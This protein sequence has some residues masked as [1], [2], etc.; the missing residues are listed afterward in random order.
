MF[1]RVTGA[2]A[3]LA[4]L[5]AAGAESVSNAT[6]AAAADGVAAT[7]VFYLS[8]SGYEGAPVVTPA[9]RLTV[10]ET[11]AVDGVPYTWWECAVA[12]EGGG[13]F[14]VRLLSERVPLTSPDGIG[15][16]HR[17]LYFDGE[18]TFDYRDGVT[19]A[20]L[21]PEIRFRED[22][23]PVPSRWAVYAD[24]FASVG[25]F[26]GHTIVRVE[27][28]PV[29]ARLDFA[30]P[31]IL[32]LRSDL[33]MAAQ[34]F[35][36]NDYV[37]LKPGDSAPQWR[38]Y[39][40][41]EVEAL[42]DAG[43]NLFAPSSEHRFWLREQ[44]VFFMGTPSY[45]DSLYRSNY[46]AGR[47]YIDEP[48]V[49]FG[50]DAA[51]PGQDLAGPEQFTEALATRVRSE[52]R[53]SRQLLDT[54]GFAGAVEYYRAPPN[55]WDTYYYSA[56]TQLAAGA[57][58]LIHEGRYKDRGYGW[59]PE[60]FFG[61]AGFEHLTF[62]DQIR[63]LNSFLRG[64]ARGWNA[65]F[66]VSVYPE[67]DPDLFADAFR[68]SYDM[69]ARY[70]WF[71][72]HPPVV[73]HQTM[74]DLGKVMQAHVRDQPRGERSQALRGAT[75]A[76]VL[77]PGY[78][79]DSGGSIW[80]MHK[81]QVS[82]GGVTYGEIAAA[83][84]GEAL[85]CSRHGIAYDIIQDETFVP[86][87][88]YER[89]VYVGKDAGLQ[90]VPPWPSPRA[91]R[92]LSV[93]ASPSVAV[94]IAAPATGPVRYT[95]A[96]AGSMVMDGSLDDWDVD[97]IPLGREEAGSDLIELT[98]AV[99]AIGDATLWA[100]HRET[101]L[102]LQFA[103]MDY[104]LRRQL[105]MEDYHIIGSDVVD[106][107]RPGISLE[108]PAVIITEIRPGS[109]AAEAGLR[110]GDVIR[111]INGRRIRWHFEV[112]GIMEAVGRGVHKALRFEITRNDRSRVGY[113]GD[114]SA[115]LGLAVDDAFLYVAADVQD[116]THSQ[117][118]S[119]WYLWQG[120]CLQIGLSPTLSGTVG[121]YSEQD[122]ELAFA[123]RDNGEAVVYRYQGRLGLPREA[124]EKATVRIRRD[125]ARTL[126]EAA[127]P[128]EDWM[129]LAPDL[130]RHCGINVV[131]NDHDGGDES[132]R[133][134]RLELVEGAMTRNKSTRDFA[135]VAFE[136]SVN[137]EKVSAALVWTRRA[138]A[139]SENHFG[140]RVAASSPES[141]R[142]VV[143]AALASLDSPETAPVLARTDLAINGDAREWDLRIET[144]SPPGRYAL[145]IRVEDEN[146]NI[147]ASDRLPVLIY[148]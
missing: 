103:Q 94:P 14:G 145:E 23:L 104:E 78:T 119:G 58:A 34:A 3:S 77:P 81:N 92:G 13:I 76:I 79:V 39:S 70:L 73:G 148:R 132:Q 53:T 57:R 33:L 27:P 31:R 146:G 46:Y 7:E 93:S 115:R 21:L 125:G 62:D 50:W 44:A 8:Q 96:R 9:L 120:D 35:G 19:G 131:I 112:W 99:P 60:A 49:R 121:G 36:R 65:D 135:V 24:G 25:T 118:F 75:T 61:D 116:D 88:G 48:A 101:I 28:R 63:Y 86:D 2:V 66:G 12:R 107:N 117:P 108:Q 54:G 133:K 51:L 102:G 84:F 18:K 138:T 74:L 122:T 68:A 72:I 90:A 139:Q 40:R 37:P 5:L 114:L 20:A 32:N 85:Y 15:R 89:L 10:G 47:M 136:P 100:A 45:P 16:V 64:A 29:P 140:L 43:I 129:P 56:W 106:E 82:E 141:R 80:G 127:V 137:R 26:L 134:G 38:D 87:L 130:W 30:D 55:T 4:L 143:H 109:P 147:A 52:C 59:S 144:Q 83:A 11:E 67:G 111:D 71:W 91:A 142:A 105:D 128:L 97:W 6:V 98:V 22:C 113:E 41:E 126:Y 110:V 42:V 1:N 17:Y 95:V 124:L 69:G 123:L